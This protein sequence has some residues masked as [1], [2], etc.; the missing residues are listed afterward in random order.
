MGAGGS[1]N[2]NTPVKQEVTNT[3]LPEYARPYFMELMGR[4]QAVTQQ[5]Y[6]AYSGPRIAGFNPDQQASFSLA[7]NL[8]AGYTSQYNQASALTNLAANNASD[9]GNR[10]FAN[11][12]APTNV[13]AGQ[14]ADPQMFDSAVASQYMNPYIQNV[15]DTQLARA[16]SLFGQQQLESA[17]QRAKAGAFGGYRHGVQDAIANREFGR[18]VSENE[19]QGLYQAFLNAQQQFNTDRGVGIDVGKYNIDRTLQADLANQNMGLSAFQANEGA[20]QAQAAN[21]LAGNS[22]LGSLAQQ[23]A[24]IGTQRQGADLA[25]LEALQRTGLQQQQQQQ[26]SL[27]LGYQDFVNQRDYER[28]NLAFMSSLLQGI[29]MP[30]QSVSSSY[31]NPNPYSQLLGLGISGLALNNALGG[32]G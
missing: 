5:P 21:F 17:G 23:L 11:T 22:Q 10:Y 3:N 8:P 24:A 29:P 19:A 13:A 27:D 30:T 16:Q 2:N 14:L 6:Q 15:L 20:R 28:N 18:Q 7:R 12:F 9:P 1:K 25:S 32:T 4:G 26:A 31:E